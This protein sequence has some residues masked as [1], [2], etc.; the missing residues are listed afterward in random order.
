LTAC[1]LSKGV[2][3]VFIDNFTINEPDINMSLP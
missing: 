3:K 2:A 1:D